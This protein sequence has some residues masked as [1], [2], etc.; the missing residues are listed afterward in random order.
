MSQNP[1]ISPIPFEIMLLS[2]ESIILLE[3]NPR[4]ISDEDLQ[5]LADD[6]KADPRYLMQRPP[7][8]NEVNGKLY[9]YAGTQR[10]KAAKLNGEE[11]IACFVEQNVPTEV[12][13][14][15]ML[16]DNLHRGQWDES[17]LMDLNFDLQEMKDFG[18]KDFEVSIFTEVKEPINLTAEMK[19]APP[20]LKLTFESTAQM[21]QFE[22]MLKDLISLNEKFASVT[23]SVSAGEI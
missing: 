5:K 21:D 23:Y 2:I 3:N 1:D 16:V 19:A 6:I 18:F 7:L 13:N 17:K 4:T 20:T 22:I 10:V 11:F 8:L 14:K 15:R 9:C 12:Q